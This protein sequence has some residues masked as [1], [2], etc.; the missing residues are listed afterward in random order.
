MDQKNLMIANNMDWYL[1]GVESCY[2][3]CW[4]EN[5]RI[6]YDI[7]HTANLALASVCISFP[8]L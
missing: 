2:L 7:V 8:A 1:Q 5:Q 4:H 3:H 6:M